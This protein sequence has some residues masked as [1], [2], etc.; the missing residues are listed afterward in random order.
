M[1]LP[2]FSLVASM[3]PAFRW[4]W[5]MGSAPQSILTSACEWILYSKWWRIREKTP[6]IVTST[7]PTTWSAVRVGK[8][9]RKAIFLK[10]L[11]WRI[12]LI[13]S[14]RMTSSMLMLSWIGWTGRVHPTPK[15]HGLASLHC[16]EA[17][18]NPVTREIGMMLDM[19]NCI[20]SECRP[21]NEGISKCDRQSFYPGASQST[22]LC[23]R[24]FGKNCRKAYLR[25]TFGEH[26][27][28]CCL[29]AWTSPYQSQSLQRNWSTHRDQQH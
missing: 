28:H 9:F 16:S 13:R 10:S 3:R 18:F 20:E 25:G 2:S 5:S 21:K 4:P 24:L 11:V 15:D 12:M 26:S 17:I 22:R 1:T 8:V 14:L 6:L 29:Q 7:Q 19:A 23:W 27:Y